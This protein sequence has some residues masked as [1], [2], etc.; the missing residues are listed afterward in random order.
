LSAVFRHLDSL[1]KNV[2]EVGQREPERAAYLGK[3]GQ[4]LTKDGREFALIYADVDGLRKLAREVYDKE[5]K[6]SD[7]R[8]EVEIRTEI[9][10]GLEFALTDAF[11]DEAPAGAKVDVFRLVDPDIAMIVRAVTSDQAHRV[12]RSA[13][14]RF[15]KSG[16]MTTTVVHAAAHHPGDATPEALDSAAADKLQKAKDA[17]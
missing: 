9:I 7:R 17:R 6:R 5:R 11:F 2:T 10:N 3:L 8:R 13:E 4:V 14:A 12:A 1:G 16:Y 15:S